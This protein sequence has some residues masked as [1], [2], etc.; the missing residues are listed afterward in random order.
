MK[1][2]KLINNI[3]NEISMPAIL[4][5]IQIAIVPLTVLL[6]ILPVSSEVINVW[7]G[8]GNWDF[9]SYHKSVLTIAMASILLMLLA[10]HMCLKKNKIKK[11]YL[12]I[13]AMTYSVLVI[14]STIL[15][16]YSHTALLG[17]PDRYE[18]LFTILAY[19]IFFAG[20]LY[21]VKNE[22]QMLLILKALVIS[23][24]VVAIIG[25]F[26]YFGFDIYKSEFGQ[27]LIIPDRY[28][29]QTNLIQFQSEERLTSGH[30]IYSSMFNP[31]TFGL[32]IA[33]LFPLCFFFFLQVEKNRN[34]IIL[35]CL[36]CLFFANLIGSFSRGSY[37]GA[38]ISIFITS[39]LIRKR[40]FLKWKMIL[41]IFIPFVVIYLGMN[42]YSNGS[43]NSKILT[44]TNQTENHAEDTKV[45]K[46]KNFT[47]NGNKLSVYC[48]NSVL[49]LS[50]IGDN[51]N[52]MDGNNKNL[53]L[54]MKAEKG[55]YEISDE[56][57]D[58]YELTIIDNLIKVKKG[59]SFLYFA[60][61]NSSFL[62]LD[63]RGIVQ[64]IDSNIKK[65]GFVGYER[66]GSGRGYIWSRTIPI[67]ER[68]IL[69]GSGP[70]TFAMEFPQNDFLGKLNY[71]YDSY[72]IIDKPHN[73]YLQTA[74]NT[75]VLSLVALICIFVIYIA[76]SINF[77][78]KVKKQNTYSIVATAIFSSMI[79]YMVSAMFTDSTVSVAPVFWILLGLGFC[80]NN[81]IGECKMV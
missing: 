25:L 15:S 12:L 58:N 55:K 24:I 16:S 18:G 70:D 65:F 28:A 79:A 40:L 1:N 23:A 27:S 26:Q 31:N 4:I 54:K 19:I 69:I 22:K 32:Y 7:S 53:M 14:L 63:S 33:M 21:F 81:Q 73:L 3:S 56:R 34:K 35:G 77:I 52:F 49:N 80:V 10:A 13:A 43:I 78:R 75:G 5:A 72:L 46:I 30:A 74:V 57:Y 41:I 59:K 71:M 50:M 38:F 37:I 17:F 48:T 66:L 39:I 51:L 11:S 45:D 36:A 61:K 44:L 67:L 64:N 9:F 20:T 47:I 6:N 29:D 2:D 68:T 8:G 62:F 60:A 42:I 76:Q